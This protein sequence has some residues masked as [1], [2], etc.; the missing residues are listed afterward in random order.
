MI[1]LNKLTITLALLMTAATGAWADVDPTVT[2]TTNKN[3]WQFAMPKG[4]VLLMVTYKDRTQTAVTYGNE[5]IPAE[6]V[7]AYLGFEAE[8]TK[9]LVATA[10]NRE[11]IW[12]FPV[13]NAE[14]FTY[15]S[16]YTGAETDVIAFRDGD[17]GYKAK[18][19]LKQL[20]NVKGYKT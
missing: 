9:K 3:E 11:N 8:F 10:K 18:G 1:Q 6:G 12:A 16:N 20:A 4:D 19:A 14:S 15:E 17:N 7:T 5:A 13:T 2:P